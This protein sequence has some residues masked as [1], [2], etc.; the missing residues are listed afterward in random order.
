MSVTISIPDDFAGVLGA[1]A[2]ER[3]RRAREALALELYREGRISAV[4]G[5]HLA[6]MDL[7]SFQGLL[8]EHQIPR[9]YSVQ[10]LHD[11]LAALDRLLGA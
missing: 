6:G 8:A 10:D 1:T 7:I 4:A 5:S 9:N 11:D 2:E 3:E